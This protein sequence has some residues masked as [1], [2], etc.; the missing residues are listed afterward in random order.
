MKRGKENKLVL[1]V[2]DIQTVSIAVASA[3][4]TVAA[5][6]YVWQ[7]RHQTKIRKTDAFWRVYQSFNSFLKLFSKCGIW[8]LRTTMIF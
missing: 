3:S 5:I 8:N 4:V 6:Y 2:V 1:R 7:I